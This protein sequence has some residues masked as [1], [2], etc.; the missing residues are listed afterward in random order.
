MGGRGGD[1][2]LHLNGRAGGGGCFVCGSGWKRTCRPKNANTSRGWPKRFWCAHF[3]Q[4]TI[5]FLDC[6][7][8]CLLSVQ[9]TQKGWCKQKRWAIFFLNVVVVVAFLTTQNTHYSIHFRDRQTVSSILS[10]AATTTAWQHGCPDGGL[11]TS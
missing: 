5:G 11:T 7:A 1:Y 6:R 9:A 2:E 4:I 10:A 3:H 8:D